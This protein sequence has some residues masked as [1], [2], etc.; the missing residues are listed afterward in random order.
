MNLAQRWYYSRRLVR[1]VAFCLPLGLILFMYVTVFRDSRHSVTVK[2]DYNSAQFYVDRY[3]VQQDTFDVV[4]H[5]Y[6]IFRKKNDSQKSILRLL[7]VEKLVNMFKSERKKLLSDEL[8]FTVSQTVDYTNC[9]AL[10]DGDEEEINNTIATNDNFN[11][12]D[13][14]APDDYLALTADCANFTTSRRYIMDPLSEVERDFPIAYSILMYKHIE[15]FERLLRAIYRPQNFYCIHV[16]LASVGDLFHAVVAIAECFPNVYVTEKR[17]KVRWGQMSV[18]EPE[19]NCMELL[20]KTSKLWKYFINLT[21]Q[22]FPLKTNYELVQ[23][24][25]AYNGANDVMSTRKK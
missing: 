16:D 25:K 5:F 6:D 23:I 8:F 21:G 18:L 7:G 22:E 24:L 11:S 3:D 17:V 12:T 20:H 4:G 10:F 13:S 1:V 19:L 9:A 2:L 15:Q 14:L